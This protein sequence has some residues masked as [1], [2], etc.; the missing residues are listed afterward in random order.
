MGHWYDTKGEPVYQVPYA[1]KR[2]GMRDTTLGDARKLGL[3]KSVTT[4]LDVP[5]KPALL[6]WKIDQVLLAASEVNF[7]GLDY[8]T[9]CK[10]VLHQA[11][12]IG[13]DSADK[14]SIIH[15]ALEQVY[16]GPCLSFDQGR[17]NDPKLSEFIEPVISFMNSRFPNVEWIS[18]E[19]FTCQEYGFGG[20]VDLYS[21]SGI[22]LD[23]KTKATSDIKKMV[24]YD[25]HHMQTAAYALGLTENKRFEYEYKRQVVDKISAA[26]TVQRYNLFIST[27]QP[28]LL[29]LTEST[30]FERDWAM[31]SALNDY[32]DLSNKYKFT[33]EK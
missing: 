29:N 23:F 10:K 3:A 25:G 17:Q 28:G 7:S 2:K 6:K 16:K 30:D 14:G 11:D 8:D 5:A 1:D 27:E 32:W 19:S 26:E 9:W 18:E 33:G 12:T 31:F 13:R 21:P 24:P 15:D 4:V 22:V 20:K